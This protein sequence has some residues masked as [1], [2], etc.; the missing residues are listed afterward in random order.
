MINKGAI[1]SSDREN[2][3]PPKKKM[4][5]VTFKFV[6]THPRVNRL[7]Q[8]FNQSGYDV[9]I[10]GLSREPKIYRKNGIKFVTFP[11]RNTANERFLNLKRL[12]A[13][14][15]MGFVGALI[16]VYCNIRNI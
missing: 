7:A 4:A 10:F 12:P 15:F 1:E 2:S 14:F 8:A 11:M 16:I 6:D 13:Q 3:A 5:F 9:T